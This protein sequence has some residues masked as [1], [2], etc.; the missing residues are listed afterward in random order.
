M[1]F[2]EWMKAN[3]AGGAAFD[4]LSKFDPPAIALCAGMSF[5]PGTAAAVATLLGERYGAYKK[6]SYWLWAVVNLLSGLRN[7]YP[8]ATLHDCD[9]GSDLNPVRLDNTALGNYPL[10]TTLT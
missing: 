6:A 4:A 1:A 7:T 3:I 9:E 5:K 8:G 2:H 10:R